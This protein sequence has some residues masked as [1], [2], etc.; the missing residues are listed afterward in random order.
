MDSRQPEDLGDG[1]SVVPMLGGGWQV[2]SPSLELPWRVRAGRVAGSAVIWMD[3]PWE[4]TARE[5]P[6]AGHRWT[7]QPWPEAE[8]MRVVHTLDRGWVGALARERA[9]VVRANRLR[10]GLLPVL[11]LLGL[12]PGELQDRWRLEWGFPAIP[13]TTLSAVLEL[14]LATLGL[15]QMMAS[16]FGGGGV[17]PAP[18]SWL[19]PISPFLFV[20][21]VV[22]LKHVVGNQEPIGSVLGLPLAVLVP[23]RKLERPQQRPQLRRLG[24]E[25]G[26]LELYSPIHRRDWSHGGVLRYRDR[27]FAMIKLERSGSGWLYHFAPSDVDLSVP[28]LRLLPPVERASG[29]RR[30]GTGRGDDRGMG[31]VGVAVTTALACMAPGDQQVRWAAAVGASPALLTVLGAGAE[32]VGAMVNFQTGRAVGSFAELAFNLFLVGEGLFRWAGLLLTGRPVGSIIGA[33]IRPLMEKALR[34]WSG[35]TVGR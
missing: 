3:R 23:R 30:H 31:V 34:R 25:T 5:G 12:V 35:T 22:R 24:E 33:A 1:V 8:A 13:A 32:V 4:V 21:S 11:P 14:G 29:D 26:R 7:L 10:Y 20:E 18:L 27:L 15:V 19:G 2:R 6:D 16:L 9:A 28:N 17:L